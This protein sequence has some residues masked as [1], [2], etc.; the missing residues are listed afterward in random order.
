MNQTITRPRSTRPS[1][2]V[3]AAPV[4]HTGEIAVTADYHLPLTDFKFLERFLE[5]MRERHITT[6]GIAGDF[7]HGDALSR[8]SPK[9]ADAGFDRELSEANHVM[10]RLLDQFERVVLIRGNHDERLLKAL[11]YSTSF[12]TSMRMALHLLDREQHERLAI[13][14]L[15]HFWVETGSGKNKRRFYVAHPTQYSRVPLSGAIK[16]A[17]KMDASVLVGHSHHMAAGYATNGRH[18]VAELGGFHAPAE[19][20]YLATTSTFPKHV[21]GYA[22]L[23]DA[24]DLEVYGRDVAVAVRPLA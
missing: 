3:L 19:T 24:G 9:Q 13:S 18:V 10:A 4:I 22:I 15:D 21:N 16:L 20:E 2:R 23:S 6:L 1:T 5:H 12:D 14:P 17:A 8:F 11:G 7:F